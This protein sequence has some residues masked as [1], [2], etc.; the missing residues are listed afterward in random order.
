MTARGITF[1]VGLLLCVLALGAVAVAAR[2]QPTS[3]HPPVEALSESRR[4]LGGNGPSCPLSLA[5]QV[6]SVNAFAQMMP[7]FR[8]PRCINCH[9][10]VDP[11]SE[12]H[13]GADQVERDKGNEQCQQCHDELE[14]WRVPGEPMFFVGKSDKEICLQMKRFEP[15]GESFVE[16]IRNDHNGTQLIAAAFKGDRALGEG[17]KD[18][19]LVVEKPPGT[20]GELTEKARKWVKAMGGQFV[21]SPECGCVK[22][23]I[24]LKMTSDWTGTGSGNTVTAAVSVTVPLKPDTS[25]LVF[26]GTAPLKHGKYTMTAPQGCRVDLKP[27]GGQLEVTQARFDIAADQR[28]TISLGVVPTTSGGTMRFICPQM[29]LPIMPILPW[30]GEWQYLHQGDIVGREYHFDKFESASGV[31]LSGEPKL[32][33][34]KEVTRTRTRQGMTVTAKTIFEF[35]WVGLEA[36]K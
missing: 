21:G 16:H 13:P 35:W 8:H 2:G 6:K 34:R 7:V 23:S 5:E 3:G 4:P 11:I 32:I 10:G 9:G 20:Q 12:K 26:K 19:G 22:P 1:P 31:S 18:Y 27:S 24:D 15:T 36:A 30:S 14:G 17:L 33:G 25:G 28:M 29:A